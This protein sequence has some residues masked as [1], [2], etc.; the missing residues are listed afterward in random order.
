MKARKLYVLVLVNQHEWI[1]SIDDLEDELAVSA[2]H[3]VR[4]HDTKRQS[5]G[6]TGDT[7]VYIYNGCQHGSFPKLTALGSTNPSFSD[8]TTNIG[9]YILSQE[10]G[11]FSRTRPGSTAGDIARVV[12]QLNLPALRKLC[13]VACRS[14]FVDDEDSWGSPAAP[15]DYQAAFPTFVRALTSELG[16][17][18]RDGLLAAGYGRFVGVN[19]QDPKMIESS[20]KETQWPRRIENTIKSDSSLWGKKV[21]F[22]PLAAAQ[23]LPNPP[24]IGPGQRYSTVTL[25]HRA[26]W[27]G[28]Y[29]FQS[30][31]GVKAIPYEQY[32]DGGW[33]P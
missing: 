7:A 9:L 6:I 22:Y 30:E 4:R 23:G 8:P 33:L 27:K 3:L 15:A 16:H 5:A 10:G 17:L 29:R 18:G 12:R 2:T 1:Q 19:N 25:Q 21:F 24:G 32:H 26:A 31:S 11:G 20:H 28:H 14:D 13:V